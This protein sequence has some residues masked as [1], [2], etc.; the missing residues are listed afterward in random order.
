MNLLQRRPL[1]RVAWFVAA[2]L[3]TVLFAAVPSFWQSVSAVSSNNSVETLQRF[4]RQ[5]EL[6]SLPNPGFEEF[7]ASHLEPNFY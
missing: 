1:R 4:D 2:L 3:C 5:S 7:A 6:A